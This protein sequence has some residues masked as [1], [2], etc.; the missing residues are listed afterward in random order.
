M[1]CLDVCAG[2]GG[3]SLGLRRAGFSTFG[4]E[5]DP[6]AAETHR[7]YVGPCLRC[8]ITTFRPQ[9]RF[10]LVAG[11]PPCQP[12]SISGQRR[13]DRDSRYLIDE[14][15]RIAY[16]ARANAV[17]LENVVGLSTVRPDL[18]REILDL[19][20]R[21][22]HTTWTILDAASYGVPQHRKR[23]F[24]VGFRHEAHQMRFSWP[25]PSHAP[26]PETHKGYPGFAR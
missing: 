12:F 10:D 26:P 25:R 22:Y 15:L 18:F 13:T 7:A 5:A 20:E 1:E 3:L 11:G 23:I 17:L 6:D 21:E 9:R 4:V 2:A 8:D 14:F 24:V 19:F 16:E